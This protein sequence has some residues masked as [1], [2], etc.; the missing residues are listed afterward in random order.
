MYLMLFNPNK[1]SE[2]QMF[3]SFMLEETE[4]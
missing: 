2:M 1:R 3:F 4:A